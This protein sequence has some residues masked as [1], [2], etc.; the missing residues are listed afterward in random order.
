M[1]YDAVKLYK[2]GEHDVA[3]SVMNYLVGLGRAGD[4]LHEFRHLVVERCRLR[5][6]FTTL[7]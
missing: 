7:C 1:R 2:T 4:Q 5:S 6:H 3:W